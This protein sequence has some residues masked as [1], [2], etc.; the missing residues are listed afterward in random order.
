MTFSAC[1][2]FI[3]SS[4]AA[5][6]A[7]GAPARKSQVRY[8]GIDLK[9]FEVGEDPNRIREELD[10]CAR[11]AVGMVA[12]FTPEK[13]WTTFLSGAHGMLAQRGDVSFVAAT[14]NGSYQPLTSESAAQIRRCTG[15]AF[16]MR[17][18]SSWDLANPSVDWTGRDMQ[19]Q[20][21]GKRTGVR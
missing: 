14:S 3:G 7:R 18:L 4:R 2:A 1:H 17:S 8:D 19:P 9:R 16:R 5:R 12:S 13:D 21:A 15:R 6:R 10:L 11:Y 20:I